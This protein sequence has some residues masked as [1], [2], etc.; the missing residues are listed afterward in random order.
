MEL[1]SQ[2]KA[3]L[4]TGSDQTRGQGRKVVWQ[5]DLGRKTWQKFLGRKTWQKS[6]GLPRQGP[7][8]AGKSLPFSLLESIPEAECEAISNCSTLRELVRSWSTLDDT[9]KG[10]IL[11][12]VQ[13]RSSSP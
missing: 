8:P 7:N 2:A 1:S 5:K 6:L 4:S 9:T 13:N 10:I 11:A 3:T 12:I